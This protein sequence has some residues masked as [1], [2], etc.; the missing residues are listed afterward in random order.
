[1]NAA[2]AARNRPRRDP[3]N[4]S[5]LNVRTSRPVD[6]FRRS[7]GRARRTARAACARRQSE[8]DRGTRWMVSTSTRA[9]AF[10]SA[11]SVGYAWH[12]TARPVDTASRYG[13]TRTVAAQLLGEREVHGAHRPV[14]R[15]RRRHGRARRHFGQPPRHIVA[16]PGKQ[17]EHAAGRARSGTGARA[18]R[19]ARSPTPPR[20]SARRWLRAGFRPQRHRLPRERVDHGAERGNRRAAAT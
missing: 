13:G 19:A 2:I 11:A 7:G 1:M 3:T 10:A 16:E 5:R 14:R 18:S 15:R 9:S 17:P 4:S 12:F 8:H 20:A 6:C